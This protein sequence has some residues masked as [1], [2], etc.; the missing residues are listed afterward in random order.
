M[1]ISSILKRYVI[2]SATNVS[3][4]SYQIEHCEIQSS[5]CSSCILDYYE[6]WL[7]TSKSLSYLKN[8]F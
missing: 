2:K 6:Q 3:S 8:M 7:W 1:L 4:F 5:I